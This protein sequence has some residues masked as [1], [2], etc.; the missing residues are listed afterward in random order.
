MD[1]RSRLLVCLL[2]I[3]LLAGCG[4]ETIA[5]QSLDRNDTLRN[6]DFQARHPNIIVFTQAQDIDQLLPQLA[7]PTMPL[8]DQLHTLD[9]TRYYA[10]L[11]LQGQSGGNS[12]IIVEH[13][14]QTEKLVAI[15]ARFTTPRPGEGQTGNVTDA[16]E[17]VA[18][19]KNGV[20]GQQIQFELVDNSISGGV[21]ATTRCLIP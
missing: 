7:Y 2:L 20:S 12:S 10:I 5:F 21:V 8:V 1:T 9:Y 3:T 4:A 15:Y 18:I 16:Y 11:L 17:L 19:P 6:F 13:V 14:K